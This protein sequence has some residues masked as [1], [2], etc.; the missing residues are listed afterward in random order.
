MKTKP[1]LNS[2]VTVADNK[3]VSLSVSGTAFVHEN[4]SGTVVCRVVDYCEPYPSIVGIIP[5]HRLYHIGNIHYV[6]VDKL[7][8]ATRH[9]EQV[10]KALAIL[11][12][13]ELL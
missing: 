7:T 5:T 3:L 1:A 2:L 4:E 6:S 8:Q 10:D 13:S 12:L 9:Q 11:A